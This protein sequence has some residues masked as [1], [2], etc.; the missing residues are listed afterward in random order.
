MMQRILPV[1]A[2][3]G[4]GL[5]AS[6]YGEAGSVTVSLP[7]AG[8]FLLS[9]HALLLV[10]AVLAVFLGALDI[11]PGPAVQRL[12]RAVPP[13]L[14][15]MGCYLISTSWPASWP[16]SW[17]NWAP[18]VILVAL[19]PFCLLAQSAWAA[20]FLGSLTGVARE[21]VTYV[22]ALVLFTGLLGAAGLTGAV[23]TAVGLA[24]SLLAMLLLRSAP[25]APAVAERRGWQEIMALA[26]VAG[27]AV[28]LAAWPLLFW[29]APAIAGGLAA[30]VVF[31]VSTGLMRASD[32]QRVSLARVVEYGLIGAASLALVVAIVLIQ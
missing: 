4:G 14:L 21:A 22:A 24:A 7:W 8:R 31:Y 29:P 16:T 9:R 17:P 23:I 1:V 30:L 15:T 12:E 11:S 18:V 27:L 6:L 2:V 10:A 13:A 26:C 32:G 5:I 25:G 20:S 3:A 28:A 19:L